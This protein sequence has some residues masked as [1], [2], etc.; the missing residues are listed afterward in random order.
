MGINNK[1]IDFEDKLVDE[2]NE[3]YLKLINQLKIHKFKDNNQL[4]NFIQKISIISSK[5][6]NLNN[7]INKLYINLIENNIKINENESSEI[8]IEKNH[9]KI[10]KKLLP[11]ILIHSMFDLE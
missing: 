10:I 8:E 9:Q 7:D 3:S 6:N 2:M 11:A 4:S 1:F 5:L